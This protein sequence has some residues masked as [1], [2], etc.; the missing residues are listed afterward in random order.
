MSDG[1]W[2]NSGSEHV[3][4]PR[5]APLTAVAYLGG[6]MAT[7]ES[8]QTKVCSQCHETLPLPAFGLLQ[9]KPRA[10]C[11]RC[12]T[13][14]SQAYQRANSDKYKESQRASR[15]RNAEKIKQTNHDQ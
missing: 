5:L 9:G 11:K 8:I 2:Y 15:V 1:T 3:S 14:R 4:L 6:T 13:K 10:E 12:L 7:D